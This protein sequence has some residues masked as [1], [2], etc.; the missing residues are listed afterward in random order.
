[1]KDFIIGRIKGGYCA[2]KGA[3]YLLKTEAS[4]QTQA[5][6]ALVMTGLG[7]YYNISTNEW[8]AQCFAI[9]MVMGLEGM[10]S[11]IEEICDFIHP[12]Y[13]K[14]IG[15]VKDIAAGGVFLAAIIAMI[16]GGLIYFPK[17]F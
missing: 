1:M 9:G 6:I 4:I 5:L 7:F 10:N 14:R 12:D 8:I 16:I 2:L 15:V 3:I 11:A 17:M 13:H